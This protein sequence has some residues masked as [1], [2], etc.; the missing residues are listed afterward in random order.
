M[1]F[2]ETLWSIVTI[3]VFIAYLM[4]MFS[5]IQDL[6]R[7]RELNGWWKALWFVMLIALPVVTA[8]VYVIARGRG[9]AERNVKEVQ[10]V[11]AATQQYIRHAAG[12]SPAEQIATAKELLE[13]GTITEAEF[14]GLKAHALASAT[15]APSH[16]A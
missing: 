10:Q 2:T 12:T 4:L 11:E 8:L 15:G 16:A 9:M 13:A 7:D 5:I 6:F 1:N 14:Q 3:F